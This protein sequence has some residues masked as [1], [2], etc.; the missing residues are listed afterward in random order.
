ML[1]QMFLQVLNM[2]LTAV[3]VIILVVFARL[4]LKK[5]PKVISYSLWGIVLFRLL[6]PI[7]F[8]SV[9]SFIPSTQVLPQA[10]LVSD[11]TSSWKINSGFQAV[12]NAVNP[13]FY[14][15]S[16]AVMRSNINIFAVIWMIGI[17]VLLVYSVISLLFLNKKLVGAVRLRKNIYLADHIASPFVIGVF[18]PKIYLPSGLSEQD[19]EYILLH[20]QTHIQRFDHIIKIIAFLT[21][22]VHWFNPAVW[23]A[24]F[25]C[26]QDMEMSCDESVMKHMNTDIR[27]EYSAL[28]LSLATGKKIIAGTPLAFGEGDTK[29]RIYNVMRYKKA[30]VWVVTLAVI[31]ACVLAVGLLT[32]PN[33]KPQSAQL[34][35][36]AYQDGKKDYNAQVYEIT[37][38][39]LS[40][41]LPEGWEVQLP[42]VSEREG[43]IGTPVYLVE[44]GEYRG[45]IAYNAF[46]LYEEEIPP[47]EFYK[48]VYG[49]LRLGSLYRWDDYT[50]VYTTE[51]T[52]TA[53]ATVYKKQEVAG[54]AAASWPE[55]QTPGIL[56]YD[57]DKL[58]YIA[59]E[60]AENAV[61]DEQLRAM[62]DSIQIK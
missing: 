7:S 4:L 33:Q 27:R 2:S 25:L 35:F 6:C 52:E 22:A 31:S 3:F 16:P 10:I 12:D 37:P 59:V 20:E 41:E 61:S 55:I 19:Q 47:E 11:N 1:N 50:P 53:L 26:A 21:L 5:A 13:Y 51:N 39:Q 14:E 40:I 36:P 32:N 60:F 46:E 57:K 45:W 30:A 15:T 8:Q 34:D 38:F 9:F 58:V 17:A 24:F 49:Q 54:E 42:P 56:S 29:K 23:L 43:T 18:H 48:T 28:L 62:A 44:N